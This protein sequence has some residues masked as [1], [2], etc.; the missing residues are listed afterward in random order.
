VIAGSDEAYATNITPQTVTITSSPTVPGT[1]DIP[2]VA[3][4]L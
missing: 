1:L 4:H 3:G 2:V